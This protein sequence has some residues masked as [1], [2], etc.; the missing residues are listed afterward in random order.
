M[1]PIGFTFENFDGFGRY[2][3][4]EAGKPVDSTGGVPIMQGAVVPNPLVLYPLDGIDG[5]AAYLAEIEDVRACF[6]NNLS[7]FSY[8]LANENKWPSS[9]KRC[10]DNA[11]R[12]EA[13]DNGNT[14][15]SVVA[16]IVHA[17]HFTRRVRDLDQ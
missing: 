16:A 5:L 2:R 15:Q 12:Q 13:R 14:V 8:G 6:V 17:P 9:E 4:T 10:T 1:D 11:I 7:Y 3:E